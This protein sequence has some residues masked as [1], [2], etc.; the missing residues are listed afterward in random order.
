MMDPDDFWAIFCIALMI[1]LVG[2]LGAV[3]VNFFINKHYFLGIIFSL[4]FGY[5]LY[6]VVNFKNNL[7]D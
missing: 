4:I 1:F 5:F 2:I 3:T 7:L 6:L